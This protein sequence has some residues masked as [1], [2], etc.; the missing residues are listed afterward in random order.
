MTVNAMWMQN[1]DYAGR[2]DRLALAGLVGG[3][4]AGVESQGAIGADS[5]TCVPR[6][7]IL[8]CDVKPGTFAVPGKDQNDQG[9]Y[10]V[11][12][13]ATETITWSAP[14]G[15]K[16]YVTVYVEVR[17]PNATGPAGDDARVFFATG[18]QAASP[19]LPTIPVSAQP[20]GHFLVES[21]D[22]VGTDCTFFPAN[23]QAPGL[24]PT[25]ALMPYA[26]DILSDFF[27]SKLPYGW[28]VCNG[29]AISRTTYADLFR[30]LGTTWGAG[31][32]STTF[33]IPDLRGRA[34]IGVDSGAGRISNTPD[35]ADTGGSE[36]H[37]LTTGEM[38]SHDH[39]GQV[40]SGGSHTHT[41]SSASNGSHSHTANSN[42][43]HQHDPPNEGGDATGFVAWADTTAGKIH[44]PEAVS[45][46]AFD[47]EVAGHLTN[48][49]APA[50]SHTHSTT[51]NGSHTHGITVNSGGAHQHGI[52]SAGSGNTHQNMPPHATIYWLIKL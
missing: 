32:G 38:P 40:N 11:H 18:A 9:T 34:L 45:F 17:D 2:L 46:F 16:W 13:D 49:T 4:G 1:V 5:F 50:G 30:I 26:G 29:S 44:G 15:D 52:P 22:V 7:D 48:Q 21:G 24:V 19:T 27:L 20:L 6:N 23:R 39:G 31:D 36:R 33:N 35:L 42:G 51:L 25:G 43:S 14:P 41:A 10:I 8:G 28:T 47:N 12:S 3:T 37:A